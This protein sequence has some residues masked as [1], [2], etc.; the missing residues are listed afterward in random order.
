LLVGPLSRQLQPDV[1]SKNMLDWGLGRLEA[2]TIG[3]GLLTY[4]V[5]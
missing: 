3:M 2:K 1:I 5:I 4:Y